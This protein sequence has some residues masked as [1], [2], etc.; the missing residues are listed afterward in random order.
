MTQSR[1]LS[2]VSNGGSDFNTL[3]RNNPGL[4]SINEIEVLNE[5]RAQYPGGNYCKFYFKFQT[6]VSFLENS[7]LI[8]YEKQSVYLRVKNGLRV[9]HDY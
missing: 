5:H 1:P 9:Q 7:A 4:Q 8:E 6:F 2:A 3:A